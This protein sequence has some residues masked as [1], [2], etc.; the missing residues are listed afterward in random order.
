MRRRAPRRDKFDFSLAAINIVL[1]LL[2]FFVVSGTVMG[3][4]ETGVKAPLTVRL[5][6]EKLP[7]P[8]LLIA[9][10]GLFL[11]DRPTG[12]EELTET[13]RAGG[14]GID[15]RHPVLNVLAERDLPAER[16]LDVVDMAQAAGVE[17]RVV[18]LDASALGDGA[19]AG[20]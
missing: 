17:V 13:L 16:L 7:R 4:N 19:P 5:P 14:A 2:F 8:L 11:N 18:T 20:Q 10:D 6:H 15:K 9:S 12:R 1:L 3:R